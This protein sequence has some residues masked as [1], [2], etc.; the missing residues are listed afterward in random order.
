VV[1]TD[2]LIYSL[3]NSQII[4]EHQ[5]GFNAACKEYLEVQYCVKII[6]CFSDQDKSIV[7]K[8]GICI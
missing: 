2:L 7:N 5:Q 6:A 8:S 1:G 3:I 4:F